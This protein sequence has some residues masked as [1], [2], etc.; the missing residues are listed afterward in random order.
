MSTIPLLDVLRVVGENQGDKYIFLD[1]ASIHPDWALVLKNAHDIGL[2]ENGKLKIVATGSHS[3]NL[4][5]AA[6]KLR[7][8]QGCLAKQFN[9]GGNFIHTPL[10][11]PEV[12]EALRDEIDIYLARYMLRRP[13]A[14]FK[15]LTELAKGNIPQLFQDLYSD[16]FQLIQNTFE[17]YLIH[18]GYPKA[19]NEFY[20]R[21]Y[22][23]PDF[24]YNV[25]KTTLTL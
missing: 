10:R 12:V 13:A 3:M 17:S 2:I 1:E 23:K 5:E 14:R 6:S 4:A 16:Y 22:I 25:Q 9:V 8:R 7:D 15:A 11:F 19:M 20:Q 21:N 24:Y 18:G